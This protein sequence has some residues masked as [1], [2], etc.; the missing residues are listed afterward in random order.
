MLTEKWKVVALSVLVV[1]FMWWWISWY[2]G[3]PQVT[4]ELP[5]P[6][7]CTM[8]AKICPDGSAVGRTGPDCAFAACPGTGS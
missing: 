4:T 1:L 7:A 5:L 2:F 3:V 6:Q 8:E